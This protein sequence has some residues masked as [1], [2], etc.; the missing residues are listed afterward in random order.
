MNKDRNKRLNNILYK[1]NMNFLNRLS[2]CCK[3]FLILLLSDS[4]TEKEKKN[5]N[6][7]R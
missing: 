6:S 1:K 2:Y 7:R 5:I 3:I 4:T